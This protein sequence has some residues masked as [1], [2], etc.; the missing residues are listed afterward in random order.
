MIINNKKNLLTVLVFIGFMLQPYSLLSQV[1]N[2]EVTL[3]LKSKIDTIIK[4]DSNKSFRKDIDFVF[5]N[6]SLPKVFISNTPVLEFYF[7]VEKKILETYVSID[8][9]CSYNI[10][11]KL[12]A[13]GLK[14]EP[15]YKGKSVKFGA[16]FP[17]GC[18]WHKGNYRIKFTFSYTYKHKL[19]IAKTQWYYISVVE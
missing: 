6:N 5:K 8:S 18:I 13:E 16:Y 9:A 1:K 7:K 14:D 17:P 15:L 3:F 12:S 4:L 19:N 2:R 11:P 10:F